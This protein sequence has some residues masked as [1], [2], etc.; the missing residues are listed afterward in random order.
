MDLVEIGWGGV[1]W[2]G[3]AQD[4]EKCRALVKAV[5]NLGVTYNAAKLSSDFET[6][7]LSSSAELHIVRVH[8]GFK[9][10]VTNGST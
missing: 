9:H 1:D 4:R 2:I 3:L 5:M 10:S 6:G 7:V 8:F